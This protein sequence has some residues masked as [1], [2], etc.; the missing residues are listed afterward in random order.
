MTV[1]VRPPCDEAV[2]WAGAVGPPV[3]RS[4]RWVLVATILA[5]GMA[6][7]DGTVVNVALPA[8]QAGLGANAGQVQWVVEAYALA[9]AA[10]LL[11]G[12]SLGDLYGRRKVF[13][14]GV[15]VF[16][17][18]SGACGMAPT[19]GWLIGMRAVQGVGAAL[20]VPGSLALIS[21]S[22]REV[23]RGKAIGTW[24]AWTA[25]TASIGPV[26][27]GWLVQHGSWR[28]V[29]FLNVPLAV[30]V[31]AVTLWRVPESRDEALTGGPDWLGAALATVGLGGV[32]YALIEGQNAGA[33]DVRLAAI[34]GVLALVGFVVAEAKLKRPMV[35]LGLFRSRNFSGANLMTLLLYGA[36][37][38]VLYFVPLNLIQ[39][40]GYPAT[41]AGAAL[42][43]MVGLIF[44][45]SSWSGGL[46]ARFGAKLPLTVGP[47]IAAGGFALLTRSGEGGSYWAMVFPAMVVLGLGMAV[48]VA[49]LTT[50]V[51]NSVPQAEAGV[52]SGVNNAVSRV[53]GLLS[54]AV[55]GVVLASTF[56]ARLTERMD[57]MK[58]PAS[59][60]AKVDAQRSRLAGAKVDDPEMRRTVDEAF[61]AGYRVV[62]LMAA[63]LAVLS[64]VSAAVLITGGRGASAVGKT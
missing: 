61:V 51:M 49:P 40:Q 14:V 26:M 12:G 32:T 38:G 5:T 6:F 3:A 19:V 24:S 8:L 57:G 48:S 43:P 9:L 10:L 34:A 46:V 36:F 28:W 30:A 39:V 35:S 54:V 1:S 25:I 42:L 16:A 50:T 11:V 21:A 29:F 23:E 59:E 62:L 47:L 20:L 18:A 60:R 4:G 22:F 13:V 15:V 55:F 31:V 44:V 33:R 41:E 7:I 63:G 27:G 2:I 58:L 53:A 52:A 56:N 64:G 45:L 17:V 37:S